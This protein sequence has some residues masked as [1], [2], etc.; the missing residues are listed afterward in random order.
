MFSHYCKALAILVFFQLHHKS[1]RICCQPRTN[2]PIQVRKDHV[3]YVN[4]TQYLRFEVE[5]NFFVIDKAITPIPVPASP[6]TH[7]LY[8]VAK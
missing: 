7:S 6:I 5:K 8:T 1:G 3:L 2:G 4:V